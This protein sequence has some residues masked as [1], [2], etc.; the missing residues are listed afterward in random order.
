MYL[1]SSQDYGLVPHTP[2]VMYVQNRHRTRD[3]W[4]TL[5]WQFYCLSE[6][7][8]EIC[9]EKEV[10]RNIFSYFISFEDVWSEANCCSV[11]IWSVTGFH[12]ASN[13]WDPLIAYGRRQKRLLLIQL[14]RCIELRSE[15]NRFAIDCFTWPHI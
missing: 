12:M 10:E 1:H 2:Y 14:V 15:V 13:S 9:W 5:S 7:L 3:F 11:V 8:P 6:F 4:E